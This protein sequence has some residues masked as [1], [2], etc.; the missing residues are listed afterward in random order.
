MTEAYFSLAVVGKHLG[1]SRED[2]VYWSR[3]A[4]A[5]FLVI[6]KS[7]PRRRGPKARVVDADG[8]KQIIVA[9]RKSKIG[10]AISV[11]RRE[12]ARRVK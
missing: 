7:D 6:P 5:T 9:Y 10:R 3:K 4:G 1:I 12:A 2:V 11:K 8:F